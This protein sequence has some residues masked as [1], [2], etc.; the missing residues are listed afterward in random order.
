[1][2]YIKRLFIDQKKNKIHKR[3]GVYPP[4]DVSIKQDVLCIF[5]VFIHFQSLA[6]NIIMSMQGLYA[7]ILVKL[8]ESE[9][10]RERE[11]GRGREKRQVKY[12][13]FNQLKSSIKMDRVIIV[14]FPNKLRVEFY[15][16]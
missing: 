13:I 9:R 6:T 11:R 12:S 16:W 15:E 7:S 5:C 4:M 8:A 3:A 14:I 1:M 10:Q 2:W